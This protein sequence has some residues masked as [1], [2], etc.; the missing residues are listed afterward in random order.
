LDQTEGNLDDWSGEREQLDDRLGERDRLNDRLGERDRLDDRLGER[1]QLDDRLGERDRLGDWFGD[2]DGKIQRVS[3][4]ELEKKVSAMLESYDMGFSDREDERSP[5]K[6]K[7]ISEFRR[8]HHYPSSHPP[9][10]MDISSVRFWPVPVMAQA[11]MT[12]TYGH[13]R[14]ELPKMGKFNIGTR[15]VGFDVCREEERERSG[16]ERNPRERGME[17]RRIPESGM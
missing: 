4:E 1:D 9:Y 14:L 16:R 8:S 2:R 15:R 13:P 6:L 11:V 3:D 12:S 10:A 5:L 17:E 7:K